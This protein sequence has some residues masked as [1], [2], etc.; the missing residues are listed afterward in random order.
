MA[1]PAVEVPPDLTTPASMNANP[2]PQGN[3][4]GVRL[5]RLTAR[6]AQPKTAAPERHCEEAEPAVG[7]ATSGAAAIS[8]RAAGTAPC[9][10]FHGQKIVV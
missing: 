2:V 9:K 7:A 6:V 1:V 3:D 5:I 4:E 8:A 10:I